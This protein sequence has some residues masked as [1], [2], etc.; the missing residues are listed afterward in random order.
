[1]KKKNWVYYVL[2]AMMLIFFYAP[3]FITILFSFNAS[4]SL[5]HWS[6]FS[7]QWYQKLFTSR[8]VLASFRVT[9]L[10]ALV[11]TLVSTIL[12]T[13]SAIG[14]TQHRHSLKRYVMSFNNLPVMN[15]EI[16]TAISFMLLFLSFPLFEKGLVTVM[17]AHITFSTP[18]VILTVLPKL[19]MIDSGSMEAAMDLGANPWQA[20]YKVLLPQLMPAIISASLIAFTMSFDDF[21]ITYFVTGNGV[22]NLSILVYT[23]A[24]RINPSINALSTML[25]I[26]ITVVL[27]SI[28]VIPVLKSKRRKVG[29]EA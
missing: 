16:V 8:D 3:I 10:V 27:I 9:L 6:G 11:S 4:R 7:W 29:Y 13:L 12:G 26:G 15:P 1:M 14:L 20:L 24:K 23:M 5:T 17:I 19:K 2:I 18:Y 25:I 28:N 21:V 22:S